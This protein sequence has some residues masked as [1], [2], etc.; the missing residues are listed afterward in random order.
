METERMKR[1]LPRC[2]RESKAQSSRPNTAQGFIVSVTVD[3]LHPDS[4]VLDTAPSQLLKAMD[5]APPQQ[6]EVLVAICCTRG[7]RPSD[8]RTVLTSGQTGIK[9]LS[10][11]PSCLPAFSEKSGSLRNHAFQK[12]EESCY[13]GRMYEK[14]GGG[15][16]RSVNDPWI[17]PVDQYCGNSIDRQSPP[18]P[19]NHRRSTDSWVELRTQSIAMASLVIRTAYGNDN[20]ASCTTIRH[21]LTS[22]FRIT[23][24]IS[25]SFSVPGEPPCGRA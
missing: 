12:A 1:S 8:N 25:I 11:P 5:S 17:E 2:S 18:P 15:R 6:R 22:V 7:I 24:D 3:L 9:C 10:V 23:T 19:C 13:E 16:R 4:R 20:R 21:I 14:T